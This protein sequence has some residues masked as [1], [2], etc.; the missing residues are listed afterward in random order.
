MVNNDAESTSVA[1]A[2]HIRPLI[3]REV[4]QGCREALQVP[5][6]GSPF[7]LTPGNRFVFDH[8][9]GGAGGTPSERLYESCVAGLVDGLFRGFN[10]TVLAYGQTGSGKT[11]T[12]GTIPEG[13]D[14]TVPYGI[15]PCVIEEIFRRKS[16]VGDENLRN[17]PASES[18]AKIEVSVSFVE[19]HKDDIR[20]LLSQPGDSPS[21]TVREVHKGEVQLFGA[22][23]QTCESIS[24]MRCCLS[25][26]LLTRATGSTNMNLNSSRSH[27]IFTIYISQTF[28]DETTFAKIHLVDLAG[29]ERVKRT[30]AEGQRLR[31]GIHINKGLLALGKV[32]S[33]LC[34]RNG[35]KSEAYYRDPSTRQMHIP[36]RDSKLTRLLQDS[37]GGN[38]KTLMIACV[39]PADINLDE[40]LNT[41]KYA[42]RA[43]NIR[44]VARR[45]RDA[46][47]ES[48]EMLR[49]ALESARDEIAYLRSCIAKRDSPSRSPATREEVS[50]RLRAEAAEAEND[51][52]SAA[53]LASREEVSSLERKYRERGLPSLPLS[54][55]EEA[56]VCS[57]CSDV[58]EDRS[59]LG[60]DVS[61]SGRRVSN[62]LLDVYLRRI[63]ELEN[64]LRE[65]R[66]HS[67]SV[68]STEEDDFEVEDE[69]D[70]DQEDDVKKRLCLDDD[71]ERE[72]VEEVEDQLKELEVL[73]ES[74]ELQMSKIGEETN[75]AAQDYEKS[76]RELEAERATLQA[77]RDRYV[78][79]LRDLEKS[80]SEE[81][82]KERERYLSKVKE[83][84][85]KLK[86]LQQKSTK[87]NG[88]RAA[89]DRSEEMKAQLKDECVRIK[90]RMVSL[91]RTLERE[92]KKN[93]ADRR[94]QERE[95]EALR[96]THRLDMIK[97]RKLEELV[98]NQRGVIKRK[99]QEEQIHKKKLAD[100]F[101][102]LAKGK[103]NSRLAGETAVMGETE[104]RS[105]MEKEI[106]FCL[107]GIDVQKILDQLT[108][109]RAQL[110]KEYQQL[111]ETVDAQERAD[112]LKKEIEDASD[113][114]HSIQEELV[115]SGFEGGSLSDSIRWKTIRGVTEARAMLRTLF[116]E[117][118]S[119]KI[120]VRGLQNRIRDLESTIRYAKS[121]YSA[122]S[123]R[124]AMRL[125][126]ECDEEVR[127]L[128]AEMESI[129]EAPL[130]LETDTREEEG[131][132]DVW[133]DNKRPFTDSTRTD[134][135]WHCE[136]ED[137]NAYPS[138]DNY[139]TEDDEEKDRTWDPAET[140][141]DPG[142]G[143]RS[144]SRLCEETEEVILSMINAKRESLNEP[145]VSRI[146]VAALRG[147]LRGRTKTSGRD[148][149]ELIDEFCREFNIA[150]KCEPS[151]IGE[152]LHTV[153]SGQAVS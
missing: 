14:A 136:N 17:D 100:L 32:I 55:E 83:L 31:E 147:C 112:T 106:E 64:E 72:S 33:A 34:D 140:L 102:K 53:L 99:T 76:V 16:N 35:S 122:A 81:R 49:R 74:K 113:K 141:A 56:R 128:L 116:K 4:E 19:I 40:T 127:S 44:N 111:P 45:N 132:P 92:T 70:D 22:S 108:R 59:A 121:M 90:K 152:S 87:Y 144:S 9:F 66:R 146:T 148:K 47:H 149:Y 67:S 18:D 125:A 109:R 91:T 129:N 63:V 24:D 21:V 98:S 42:S 85:G 107:R 103:D 80:S 131:R 38:S 57:R 77:E 36:Y 43:R 134:T 54:G 2:V 50:W 130:P 110:A 10:A 30:H 137:P 69:S 37:L 51:R 75:R 118:V 23:R 20:D 46:G 26:G 145:A 153:V 60:S 94:G 58:S 13:Q 123:A 93:M 135:A 8:V 82:V 11:Y 78:A 139:S 68:A 3:D 39:S 1:V 5:S 71:A 15:V 150:K 12:M 6:D 143:R 101:E 119:S 41:L 29:S 62:G 97:V 25:Q 65:L 138:D 48:S 73:L 84:E 28:E 105:W 115:N 61:T 89:L 133:S 151:L 120:E 86:D 27:A 96:K 95:L 7:I 88:L 114:I 79:A 142:R 124:G 126:R 104:R 117:A 52:L